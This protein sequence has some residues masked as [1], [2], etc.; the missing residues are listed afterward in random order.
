M[1]DRITQQSMDTAFPPSPQWHQPHSACLC[2]LSENTGWLLYSLNNS[3]HILNPFTLKYQGIL[4]NGHTA[5]IN[6]IASRPF[7]TVT[8]DANK[9]SA[10]EPSGG[11]QDRAGNV[12]I[13]DSS[14]ARQ[15]A[16]S[17]PRKALLASG[18][19]DL[20]VVCWDIST[21]RVLASLR[22]LHQKAVRAVEWTG[23]GRFIVS[24]DKG[25]VV[26]LWCPFQ[27]RIFKKVLPEKPSISCISASPTHADIVAIGLEGGDILVCQVSLTR[28][29]V[30][31][32]LHGH[33]EKIQSLS[34][35]PPSAGPNL[36]YTR[37]A[38][39]SADQTIRIWDVEK[40]TSGNVLTQPELDP[41][42]PSYQRSKIWMPVDWAS[43]GREVLSATGRKIIA[44]DIENDLGI[45]QIECTG[46]NVF[47]LD[48]GIQDPGRIAMGLGNE[49]IKIWNTLG[50][51]EPY[52]GVT[53]ERL[54]SK[55][56]AVKWHPV[57]EETICFG[58]ESGKIGMIEN[59]LAAGG[60]DHSQHGKQGKR[61]KQ[62][63][64]GRGKTSQRQTI[65]QSY[66]EGAV[67]SMT[68]CSL[69]A[70]EAPVPELFDL[71][72][73]EPAFCI[74]SCGSDGK[75]LVSN[76][77]NPANKSLDLE[78]V[79][80]T[81]NSSWYQSYRVIKGVSSPVRRDFAVHPN[82]DLMAIGNADG[83]VEVFE[84]KYFKLVYVYQG[85]R[86]R[87][88]RLCWN[89]TH[90]ST[91]DETEEVS[92]QNAASYLL[93]SGSDDGTLVVHKLDQFTSKAIAERRGQERRAV[94]E[95][96]ELEETSSSI[97]T[98]TAGAVL[99]TSRPFAY[100]WC[101][102]RGIADLAWSPHGSAERSDPSS[103]QRLVSA[104]YDGKAVV[105]QLRLSD[106]SDGNTQAG[107]NSTMEA[108]AD[109]GVVTPS[110]QPTV[111]LASEPRL[112]AVACFSGHEGQ[113]TSVHWSMSEVDRIYSGG[114][115]W[116]ACIWDWRSHILTDAQRETLRRDDGKTTASKGGVQP[117]MAAKSPSVASEASKGPV[118]NLNSDDITGTKDDCISTEEEQQV[119][120]EGQSQEGVSATTNDTPTIST[121]D[122]FKSTVTVLKRESNS[123]SSPQVEATPSKR[124]RTNSSTTASSGGHASTTTSTITSKSIASMTP[125]RRI[126]LFPMSSAAFQVQSKEKVHLEIIRLARNLYCRR[127]GQGGVLATEEELEAARRRWQDMRAFFERDGEEQG[128]NLSRILGWDIDEMNFGEFGEEEDE[129]DGSQVSSNQ[130][131]EPLSVISPDSNTKWTPVLNGD[132]HLPKS[133]DMA[134]DIDDH[135]I[136]SK[137][138][139]VSTQES[140][141]KALDSAQGDDSVVPS[142]DL[143]FY[144]SRESV[145]ALAEMEAQELSKVQ[146]QASIFSVGGGLG[147]VPKMADILS[148]LPDTELGIQDWIGIALSP[149]GGAGAWRDMM[150]RTAVKFESRGEGHAAVLCYLG[151]GR[152]VEAVEVYRKLG[153]YREALMLLRIRLWDDDSDNGDGD[154]DNDDIGYGGGDTGDTSSLGVSGAAAGA[155][156]KDTSTLQAQILTEWGQQLERRNH[157]EQACKCQLALAAVL[158]RMMQRQRH[159]REGLAV[160]DAGNAGRDIEATASVGLQTLARRA[161]V[162][163]LRTVAGLAILLNDPTQKER[164]SVYE[165]AMANKRDADRI[166]RSQ[167][168]SQR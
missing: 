146:Y 93:A 69:K 149:M 83:S 25:G 165:T 163:T 157:Y 76:S 41:K 123:I 54:Q 91:V 129:N 30:L 13:Q 168:E 10:L 162:A 145:R 14:S 71:S 15:E 159:R 67:T 77:S 166:R 45:A 164:V 80:Q 86:K 115:D 124:A 88:N 105:Y 42:M 57:E 141:S 114:N 96:L 111:A 22:K 74:V 63:R 52:E 28:F 27:N 142:G 16:Q 167:V 82:E 33:T 72:L 37:L 48:I 3:V 152:V 89:Y 84:L 155:K 53:I 102:S 100:A 61:Q 81:Q 143:I 127:L 1:P 113:V 12:D 128:M 87:V 90:T 110:D 7:S 51:E 94:A 75:I 101:H 78:I 150:A 108:I 107:E 32:R 49:S 46:G 29:T 56:R 126:N 134:Q 24:G 98:D 11:L 112:E 43:T 36:E 132:A 35:Q 34:W 137:V 66:H 50:Q 99:P 68:W 85:H 4:R 125:I 70:F 148:A 161:D 19:D 9:G 44:W 18:G 122:T 117:V 156:L 8:S 73:R 23:D 118:S 104:S 21:Q 139:A 147:D 138:A 103:V 119:Q 133:K 154:G 106:L 40:E 92:H 151:I 55:V 31:R 144:G 64:L 120:Q 95:T 116:R 5:R 59:T 131:K 153:L 140:G 121:E 97:P 160:V 62:G 39:G 58:L 20:T 38:S 135:S 47:S 158:M 60:N 79:L 17:E 130:V 136:I 109:T 65:F 6:C 26:I 2:C